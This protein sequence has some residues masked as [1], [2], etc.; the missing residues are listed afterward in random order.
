MPARVLLNRHFTQKMQ[1][2]QTNA[3]LKAKIIKVS[4]T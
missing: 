2:P 1:R 4:E 3:A